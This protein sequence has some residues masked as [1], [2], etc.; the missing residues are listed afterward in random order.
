MFQHLMRGSVGSGPV[1]GMAWLTRLH[2]LVTAPMRW[3][4]SDRQSSA[5]PFY[6]MT[7]GSSGVD[8]T[9]F[10]EYIRIMSWVAKSVDTSAAP[11]LDILLYV[12][13][14]LPRTDGDAANLA[15]SWPAFGSQ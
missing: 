9:S 13:S 3:R 4:S 14:F 15:R 7:T 1:S 12:A 8:L 6:L 11:L 5:V 10:F 2:D